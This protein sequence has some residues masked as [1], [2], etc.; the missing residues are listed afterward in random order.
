MAE[1]KAIAAQIRRDI[2]RMVHGATVD[3]RVDHWA[4]QSFLPLCILK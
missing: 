4:V 2:V 1:L 3:I